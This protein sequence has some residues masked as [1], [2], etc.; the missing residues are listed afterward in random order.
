GEIIGDGEDINANPRAV[1]W[2]SAPILVR[3]TM[4]AGKIKVH[5]EVQFPGVHAPEAADIVFE[6]A[7]YKGNF[8]FLPQERKTVKVR[9][10]TEENVS[11][12]KPLS[13]EEKQ[14]M[15]QEVINQQADFGITK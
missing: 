4:K 5:A 6:S 12:A 1:E 3:S 7:P 8:C 14:K 15:L 10:D 9:K 11:K 13:E 2:G